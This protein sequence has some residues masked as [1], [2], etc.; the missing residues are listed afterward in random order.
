MSALTT[1]LIV[2]VLLIGGAFLG[3]LLR[4]LL[5]DHQLDGHAK[6]VVRLGC[7]LVATISGLVLGLLVSSAKTTYDTQRDEVRQFTV[8]VM[9][10]DQALERLGP[11]AQAG[12]VALRAAVVG[13]IDRIWS[14]GSA[15][16]RPKVFT[17]IPAGETAFF[18]I[19]SIAPSTDDE[20]FFQN[21]ALQAITSILQ[22]RLI[23]FQQ[24]GS[25]VPPILLCILVF[26]L[27]VLFASFSLFSPL[28]PTAL[29][30]VIVFALSVSSAIF[31]I[32]EMYQ[33]FAG[34]MQIDS[35]PLRQALA[36]IG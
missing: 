29:T 34:V 3:V 31:L 33:P 35:T 6:D 13:A 32:L 1:S 12:R 4:R 27:V 10:L 21:E 18:A 26:W 30:A 11:R 22:A 8:N 5:P 25:A 9:L 7:G 23:L 14:D 36:P 2:C 19:R 24:A 17:T 28:N 16:E 20:R 15:A